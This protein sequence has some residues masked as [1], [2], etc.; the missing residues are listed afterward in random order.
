MY[1]YSVGQISQIYVSQLQRTE[2]G[3]LGGHRNGGVCTCTDVTPY[4]HL[5]GLGGGAA[6]VQEA[7]VE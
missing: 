7:K 5:R 1:M 6:Q 4:T 3:G 2:D